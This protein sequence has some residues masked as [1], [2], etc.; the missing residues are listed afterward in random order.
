MFAP[1]N[2]DHT[3]STGSEQAKRALRSKGPVLAAEA[4]ND[5]EVIVVGGGASGLMAAGQAAAC[6]A[7]TL[8]FETMDRPGRKIGLTGKGRCNL[9]NDT[10]IPG[11]VEAFGESGPFL[12]QAF[13]RFFVPE[14]RAFL[15][16]LGVPTVVERGRRV[17]PASGRA[18]DVVHALHRWVRRQG[19]R[20]RTGSSVRSLLV[21]EGRVQGV[22]H[23]RPDRSGNILV[24]AERSLAPAVVLSAGG[25]SYPATGS[26]GDGYRMAEAAG[27]HVVPVRPAL[28]PLWTAE[29]SWFRL[30]GLTLRN[31]RVRVLADGELA[32]SGFGELTFTPNGVSGPVPLSLSRGVVDALRAGRRVRLSVDL[33]PALDPAGLDARLVR[34][35]SAG[36]RKHFE[37]LLRG[38]MPRPLIPLCL[39]AVGVPGDRPGHQVRAE[40]RR[41]LA[42]WLKDIPFSV[43]GHG[44][45]EE[46]VV[47]AGGVD[48]SEIDPRTMASRILTG[49][50]FAG[51]VIDMDA[52]TGGFNLQAAFSTGWLAGRSAAASSKTRRTIP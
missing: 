11:F 21:E 38:L 47:T 41:R 51:E 28:V 24:Q 33:K 31:V 35:L 8:V 15:E 4:S 2:L 22:E 23:V 50:Y 46:A 25:A 14:L 5:I 1:V 7:R 16:D 34:D 26:T 36:G 18:L 52:G 20:L 49:L 6:G 19:A 39:S 30:A 13:H 44:S 17:F 43:T 45:F 12:R 40:Q 37:T 48:R 9:T 32:Q 3:V 29:A 42:A 27:H 10:D